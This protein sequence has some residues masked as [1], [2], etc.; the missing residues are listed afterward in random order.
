MWEDHPLGLAAY[1][2]VTCLEWRARGG[3]DDA[4]LEHF[5]K[6]LAVA[7]PEAV[8]L[9]G[10]L[11][12][13]PLNISHQSALLREDPKHYAPFFPDIPNDLPYIWPTPEMYAGLAM[14]YTI[15][16]QQYTTRH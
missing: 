9:P 1:G 7:G 15:G 8:D 12:W 13:A 5:L 14:G 10:W 3:K 6:L 2:A 4:L 11:Q 16:V